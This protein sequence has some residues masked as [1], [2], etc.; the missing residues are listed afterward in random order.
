ML[1]IPNKIKNRELFASRIKPVTNSAILEA[2]EAETGA[3]FEVEHADRKQ[4]NGK[5]LEALKN[6]QMRPAMVGLRTASNYDL[7]YEDFA[8]FP[9]N[10]ENDLVVVK[11]VSAG[12]L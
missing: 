5:V 6:G 3:K 9:R 12:R 2:V 1:R 11:S 10:P 8:D 7:E 4:V